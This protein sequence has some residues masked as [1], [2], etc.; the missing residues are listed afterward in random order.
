MKATSSDTHPASTLREVHYLKQVPVSLHSSTLTGSR[1]Q[2]LWC[3]FQ[4]STYIKGEQI[5]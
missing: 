5:C 3:L 2:Y 1:H 4:S